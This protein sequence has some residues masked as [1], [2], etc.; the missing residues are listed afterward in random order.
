LTENVKKTRKPLR[1]P[2]SLHLFDD[3]K[4]IFIEIMKKKL[5]N[6]AEACK[7]MNITRQTFYSWRQK[8]PEFAQALNEVKD[9][10]VDYVEGKMFDLIEAGDAGA[11]TLVKFYLERQAKTRGY[12]EEKKLVHQIDGLNNL[13]DILN[14]AISENERDY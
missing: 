14:E 10:C 11:A 13:T 12:A 2:K 7:E 1:K 9:H 5:G 8:C 4:Q 3:K 6:T